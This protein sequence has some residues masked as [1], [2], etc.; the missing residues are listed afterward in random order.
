MIKTEEAPPRRIDFYTTHARTRGPSFLF[1]IL[2]GLL[3]AFPTSNAA[4][5]IIE[6]RTM[7]IGNSSSPSYNA[8][9]VAINV[10]G[11]MIVS[12]NITMDG[13]TVC[14]SSNGL[15]T[16]VGGGSI[17]TVRNTDGRLNVTNGSTVTV[18]FNLS[19]NQDLNETAK[20]T[21]VNTSSNIGFLGRV[22]GFNLTTEIMTW[23]NTY[24]FNVTDQRYNESGR[25][26][27]LNTSLTANDS[28]Q[29]GLINNKLD[30]TDQ[31]YN[32]SSRAY[33]KIVCRSTSAAQD[34]NLARE[35]DIVCLSTDNDCG[36]DIN[37]AVANNT[38]LKFR[39]GH[40]PIT[41]A[42]SK[43]NIQNFAMLGDPGTILHFNNS[44][45]LFTSSQ[46]IELTNFYLNGTTADT[47]AGFYR[48]TNSEGII[49]SY[50]KLLHPNTDSR[51]AYIS[52]GSRVFIN[53]NIWNSN[54]NGL[55][56]IDASGDNWVLENNYW[57]NT[58][59]ACINAFGSLCNARFTNNFYASDGD[60][61]GAISLEEYTPW[62][63]PGRNISYDN[64]I[65]EGNTFSNITGVRTE[66]RD[67]GLQLR[68][69]S[70][71]GNTF[72]G[73]DPPVNILDKIDSL[74]ISGNTMKMAGPFHTLRV[75]P[76][77]ADD[78]VSKNILISGN[79][80]ENKNES[81]AA[82]LVADSLN[83]SVLSNQ[84]DAAG[85][86]VWF[87][88]RVNDS[89]VLGNKMHCDSK[90]LRASS[91]T[92]LFERNNHITS[93]TPNS[94]SSLNNYYVEDAVFTVLPTCNTFL[95]GRTI[96]FNGS[97]VHRQRTCYNG[98][99]TGATIV[100]IGSN[101]GIGTAT[102]LVKFDV[103][104]TINGTE[105]YIGGTK[106]CRADGTN[107][108]AATGTGNMSLWRIGI[109]TGNNSPVLN[110]TVVNIS[111]G[112][113]I[114]LTQTGT[115]P[116]NIT[117]TNTGVI[118]E[119]D[120]VWASNSS[121]VARTGSCTGGNSTHA[122][123]TNGT[124]TTGV[125]CIM[126]ARDPG[127]S[128]TSGITTLTLNSQVNTS[129][130]S[131]NSIINISTTA[132]SNITIT[133]NGGTNPNITISHSDTSSQASSD[134][135]GRTYIQDVIVDGNGHVTG[136]A[137]ATESV[138]DTNS[139]YTQWTISNTSTTANVTNNTR[140]NITGG[141]GIT[142]QQSGTQITIT[143]TVTDTNTD[144]A[145]FV[146]TTGYPVS[147]TGFNVTNLS[148]YPLISATQSNTAIVYLGN[149][150]AFVPTWYS[151]GII[152][153][154]TGRIILGA[155]STNSIQLTTGATYGSAINPGTTRLYI[156]SGGLVGINTT[157]PGSTLEI[158]GSLNASSIKVGTTNVCL[159]DGTN[160]PSTATGMTEWTI[161]NGSTTSTV[162]NGT[163]VNITAG[164]GIR[165]TQTG[166]DI[167]IINTVTDTDTNNGGTS[168]ISVFTSPNGSIIFTYNSTHVNATINQSRFCLSDG[169]N[170]PA[171]TGNNS[172]NQTK[173][174]T[175][176]EPITNQ[177]PGALS[178]GGNPQFAYL[179]LFDA[180]NTN[181]TAVFYGHNANF[182]GWYTGIDEAGNF[183]I[184]ANYQSTLRENSSM[185]LT[186][187]GLVGIGTVTPSQRLDVNGSINA[188][189]LYVGGAGI[190]VCRSDGTNCP[191]SNGN[192]SWNQT[193]AD[194]RYYLRTDGNLDNSSWNQ[195]HANTLY[196]PT[197][198]S[199]N[200][201]GWRNDTRQVFLNNNNTNV[202]IGNVSGLPAVL[203]IDNA[204][205]RVGI[206]TTNLTNRLE[207]VGTI[208]A[209]AI[210]IGTTDVLTAAVTSVSA[211]SFMSFT[212][213]TSTGSISLDSAALVANIGNWSL[214]KNSYQTTA[215]ADLK[216][217]AAAT[218]GGWRNS[219]NQVFLNSNTTNVSINHKTLFIDNTNNRTGIGTSIPTTTLTVN[220]SINM[221]N[222]TTESRFYFPGG[223]YMTGNS[224]C[225]LTYSPDG[226]LV[227]ADCD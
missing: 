33:D 51:F 57:N 191:A 58:G 216:Y 73:I 173:A 25:I 50:N 43:T 64:I 219:T 203:F 46:N 206:G 137:T 187:G 153:P 55:C 226:G 90:G 36:D 99:W 31:R 52:N 96:L 205:G 45:I 91:S 28:A 116:I 204:N 139:G 207:V 131:N 12:G 138:T 112:A 144:N 121:T 26:T 162:N 220:G 193:Y 149:S 161:S 94:I 136:L 32:E 159:S 163:R 117:I 106:V 188:T 224:T 222:S 105:I 114:S 78:Y 100:D 18:N 196:A 49:L 77:G 217:L 62:C 104:G 151:T 170:C 179:T 20:I 152:Q 134:N 164:T 125:T 211:G 24:F 13:S 75:V 225:I 95:E 71:I 160:C 4:V 132:A 89:D 60:A 172:W 214:D 146:N 15:C 195:T 1:L 8:S 70:I 192:S 72:S 42:I 142:V 37:N 156:S 223:G 199:S 115:G 92:N 147:T 167:Q 53:N 140:V 200:A 2:M 158:V 133:H 22:F 129:S 11:S 202:S 201:G 168:N 80:I 29:L 157:S 5:Y 79:Y 76:A 181:E 183:S 189:E 47:D 48:F 165:L 68:S 208:N 113:G 178:T 107:C 14:T 88:G 67:L 213:I 108:I 130:L 155:S 198:T 150:T 93:P 103:N 209:S 122:N 27:D 61:Y 171:S 135:S 197:T 169:S 120:P 126:V 97:G 109:G 9:E 81:Y 34:T 174:D 74:V 119:S 177:N 180:S 218:Q 16:G 54:S 194:T 41:T 56:N 38:V 186:I 30:T 10:A 87:N 110:N 19:G 63:D 86:C 111:A 143:N 44:K 6:H 227:G 141:T 210:K 182:A 145:G 190:K 65:I 184:N 148:N 82:V 102:P 85:D 98:T 176:Y 7:N 118:T 21:Q 124:T 128:G 123:V 185:Y 84:I 39:N 66:D 175:L 83:V 221:T 215:T 154:G 127:S 69:I 59:T 101:I 212:T 23:V 17:V 166:T 3:L 40:F 35:C